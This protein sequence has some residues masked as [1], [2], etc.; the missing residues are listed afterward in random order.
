MALKVEFYLNTNMTSPFAFYLLHLFT[1]A[2]SKI[3]SISIRI[4]IECWKNKTPLKD[5]SE[6]NVLTHDFKS[7]KQHYSSSILIFMKIL[8]MDINVKY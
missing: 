6:K 3:W 4:I 5:F 7:L 8:K 2:K 1:C